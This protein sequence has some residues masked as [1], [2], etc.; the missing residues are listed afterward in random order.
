[1]PSHDSTLRFSRFN[2]RTFLAASA[3][4][5]LAAA[6]GD[7]SN[8]DS[9]GTGGT[10]KSG[11]SLVAFFGPQAAGAVRLPFGLGDRDGVLLKDGPATLTGQF[12]TID[13]KAI[14]AP[15]T[16]N[17][18]VK[19]LQ[20]AYYP[21]TT[22]LTTPGSY[23]LMVNDGKDEYSGA[24]SIV[25]PAKLGVPRPGEALRSVDTPTTAD[26]KGVNPICTRDPIC[27]LH[28]V[29]LSTAMAEGKPIAL[30]I[31]TPLFC[32][33]AICGPVLDVLL[34]Q[35][36]TYGDRVTFIHAEVYTDK[37]IDKTTAAVDAYKLDY[38]PALFLADA[39]G[40]I[41][42]RLD[43]IYDTDELVENLDK[44]VNAK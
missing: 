25:D 2:R 42:N 1:M 6:C 7:D 39:T 41:V 17:R 36:A 23:Q 12:A 28:N 38:E 18:H 10:S 27:P 22:E 14:G 29:S 34:G 8:D 24:F 5:A 15:V 37:T 40:K 11:R 19:D 43:V 13:G 44:L 21:F 35:R 31:A 32:K 26:A 9:Q 16:V 33:T 3:G 30:L 4:L 20:R